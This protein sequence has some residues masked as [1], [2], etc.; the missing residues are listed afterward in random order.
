[1]ATSTKYFIGTAALFVVAMECLFNITDLISHYFWKER[2]FKLQ[3]TVI[4]KFVMDLNQQ[5]FNGN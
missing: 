1:M 4:P 2:R 5:V 3:T